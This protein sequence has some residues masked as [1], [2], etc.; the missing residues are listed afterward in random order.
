[1]RASA[2]LLLWGLLCRQP[3]DPVLRLTLSCAAR[4]FWGTVLYA[5]VAGS[6]HKAAGVSDPYGHRNDAG[7]GN[8]GR[9]RPPGHL[10]PPALP[11]PAGVEMDPRY[12]AALFE[13][14][15][16]SV[17]AATM[18]WLLETLPPAGRHDPLLGEMALDWLLWDAP[19]LKGR[20]AVAW[21]LRG[22]PFFSKPRCRRT[23]RSILRSRVGLYTLHGVV[24]GKGLELCDLLT[25][26]RALVRTPTPAWP[27]AGKRLLVR[28]YRFGPWQLAGGEG[29]LLPARPT[30]SL[31]GSV[32]SLASTA[33]APAWPDPRWRHWLKCWIAPLAA[34]HWLRL[35]TA[36]PRAATGLD[37]LAQPHP[38]RYHGEDR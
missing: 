1:M 9:H 7:N 38:G 31:I 8:A 35:H 14:L 28:F 10:R 4:K 24:A 29:L 32:H 15:W 11:D 25:G 36:L 23:A 37:R 18:A 20:P 13:R 21:L 26:S 17:D 16:S 27:D 2:S 33:R 19:W 3:V 12:G 30:R 34:R 5:P 22:S 6:G